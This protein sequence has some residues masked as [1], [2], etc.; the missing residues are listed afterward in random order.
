SYSGTLS[1]TYSTFLGGGTEI[2]YG[3]AVDGS[4][5]AYVIGEV[6]GT[7][8]P[9]APSTGSAPFQ[10]FPG[11]PVGGVAAPGSGW[12][13]SDAFV[14]RLNPAGSKFDFASYLGGAG[15]D[16]ARAVALDA[17]GNV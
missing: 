12:T 2:G 9:T 1:M 16:N 15:D 13:G 6:N 10:H 14:A 7:N 4:G 8:F 5:D 3:I 17:G 11:A